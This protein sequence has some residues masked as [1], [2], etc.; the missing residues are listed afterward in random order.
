MTT[1][2]RTAKKPP[3]PAAVLGNRSQSGRREPGE[4]SATDKLTGTPAERSALLTVYQRITTAG[5][6]VG[7]VV[8][9]SSSQP[10][11]R[12][13]CGSPRGIGVRHQCR[14]VLRAESLKFPNS[15]TL[16]SPLVQGWSLGLHRGAPDR[17]RL[18][19]DPLCAPK[20]RFCNIGDEGRR[21]QT[22][23]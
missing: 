21:G 12:L 10:L 4:K 6:I 8:H 11:A 5:G 17:A 3:R 18:P 20:I 1:K 22:A 19:N 2:N 16:N 7:S 9:A 13:R 23:T 14:H 15:G